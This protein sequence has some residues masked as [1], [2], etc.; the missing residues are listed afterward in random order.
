MLHSAGWKATV[1]QLEPCT[2]DNACEYEYSLHRP[3][4]YVAALLLHQEVLANGVPCVRHDGVGSYDRN[5]ITLVDARRTDFVSKMGGGVPVRMRVV[6]VRACSKTCQVVTPMQMCLC[7]W[8]SMMAA[9]AKGL[10]LPQ[11]IV[12]QR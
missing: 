5:L 2:N 8:Q 6:N 11:R 3:A 10:L 1:G 12:H 9:A 7:R 4:R